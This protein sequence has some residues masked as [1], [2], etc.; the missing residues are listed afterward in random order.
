MGRLT[1]WNCEKEITAKEATLNDEGDTVCLPCMEEEVRAQAGEAYCEAVAQAW[2]AYK[3]AMAQAG[4]AY[5][6]AL[7]QAKV[8][9]QGI[10][11]I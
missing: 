1:C 10:E 5:D 8:E 6:E 7:A 11:A 9:W 3:E 4:Q 2:K